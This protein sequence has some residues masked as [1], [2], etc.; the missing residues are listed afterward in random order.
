MLK[1]IWLITLF[2]SVDSQTLIAYSDISTTILLDPMGKKL[3][4]PNTYSSNNPNPLNNGA[5]VVYMDGPDTWPSGTKTTFQNQFYTNCPMAIATLTIFADDYFTVYL[6]GISIFSGN[7]KQTYT[8]KI[9]LECGLN[10]LTT[11]VT[12]LGGSGG[13]LFAITQNQTDCYQCGYL[14]HYEF[15]SCQCI[16]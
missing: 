7:N 9:N 10:N 1:F 8:I 12:N 6:N 15:M 13:Y 4:L 3:V 14:S 5:N 16:C 2:L 11:I